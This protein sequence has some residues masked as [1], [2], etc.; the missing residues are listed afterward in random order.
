LNI[1][2]A[3]VIFYRCALRR[4]TGRDPLPAFS[5]LELDL[6]ISVGSGWGRT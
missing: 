2:G 3:N 6:E 1:V 5:Q 4:D